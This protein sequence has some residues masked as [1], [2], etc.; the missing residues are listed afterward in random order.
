[1][2]HREHRV[3]KTD[4]LEQILDGWIFRNLRVLC[5]S[6]VNNSPPRPPAVP[7]CPLLTGGAADGGEMHHFFF[8]RL[9]P[10]KFAAQ[11]AVTHDQDAICQGQ[12]F[13]KIT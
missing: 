11:F 7:L 13:W 4:L 1:L 9:G 5:V 8:G 10:G 2:H 12:H 6:V 3:W